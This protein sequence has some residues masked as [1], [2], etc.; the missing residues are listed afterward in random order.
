M[1]N[2]SWIKEVAKK[3]LRSGSERRPAVDECEILRYRIAADTAAATTEDNV[4][5]AALK[6]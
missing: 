5:F 4:G 6:R 2:Q 3:E 1:V